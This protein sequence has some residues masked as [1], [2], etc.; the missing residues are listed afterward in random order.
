[1]G[2]AA[3]A[4]STVDL[5]RSQMALTIKAGDWRTMEGRQPDEELVIRPAG[6]LLSAARPGWVVVTGWREAADQADPVWTVVQVRQS[7]VGDE[8]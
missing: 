5:T 8:P 1:M 3:L 6:P 7:A 2:L 4:E